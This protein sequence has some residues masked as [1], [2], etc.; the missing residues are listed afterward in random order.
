MK[1]MKR[2]SYISAYPLKVMEQ[3]MEEANGSLQRSEN[4]AYLNEL[5]ADRAKSVSRIRIS[6]MSDP[7]QAPVND[8]ISRTTIPS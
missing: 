8:P 1:E 7:Y 4:S 6:P 3:A 2:S 5:L